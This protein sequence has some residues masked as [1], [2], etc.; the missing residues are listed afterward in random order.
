MSTCILVADDDRGIVKAIRTRLQRKGYTVYGVTTGR[1]A[2]S[3]FE[4]I[5]PDVVLL[6]ASMPDVSGL[7]VCRHIRAIDSDFRTRVYIV[8]GA[9]APSEEYVGRCVDACDVDGYLR[10]PLDWDKLTA[11][12]ECLNAQEPHAEALA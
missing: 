6:D 11:L 9:S 8:S 10:K 2:I 3:A 5:R 7:D 4:S 12:L 1:E